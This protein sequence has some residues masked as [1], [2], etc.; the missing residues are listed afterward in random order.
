MTQDIK[1]YNKTHNKMYN[2][3]CIFYRNNN[4]SHINALTYNITKNRKITKP[5][6]ILLW[7]LLWL[8]PL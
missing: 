2:K 4:F 1:T 8:K 5:K 7:F 6:M 3:N